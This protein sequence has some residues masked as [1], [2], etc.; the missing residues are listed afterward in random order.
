[1]SSALRRVSDLL[2]TNEGAK[3]FLDWLSMDTTQVMLRAARELALPKTVD[4]HDPTAL[5]LGFGKT[6]GANEVLD[7]LCNPADRGAV[8]MRSAPSLGRP[9][10]GAQEI[11]KEQA[12]AAEAPKV[13]TDRKKE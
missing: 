10:Y 3:A 9:T 1:M 12:V 8:A 11:L 4:G 2:S 7:Y 5:I 13:I 6:L